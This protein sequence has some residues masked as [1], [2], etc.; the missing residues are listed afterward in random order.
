MSA[1]EGSSTRNSRSST[2]TRCRPHHD[3]GV[4]HNP[5]A[6][7][8]LARHQR[9]GPPSSSCSTRLLGP[10]QQPQRQPSPQRRPPSRPRAQQ[11]SRPPG[12]P[13]RQ[14]QPPRPG[15]WRS[16]LPAQR[17]S[18]PECFRVHLQVRK[19]VD[20]GAFRL[21]RVVRHCHPGPSSIRGECSYPSP[22]PR[23]T[24]GG[25]RNT[26]RWALDLEIGVASAR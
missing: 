15:P 6:P 11:P 23:R 25:S 19:S 9:H 16:R 17:A 1:I 8:T 21:F 14:Q 13:S 26:S 20:L 18:R 24:Q 7:L 12:A 3:Q 5:A 22:S 2:H 10:A 4:F